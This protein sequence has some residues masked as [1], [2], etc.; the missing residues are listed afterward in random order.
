MSTVVIYNSK[1][2][3]TKRYADLI[4]EATGADC[5]SLADAKK[6]DLTTYD[7]IIFGS[8][9]CAG[10]MQKL[11]WFKE[12]LPKLEGKNLLVYLVGA[13]PI[14]NPDVAEGMKN[15]FADSCWD[16]VKRFYCPGGLNYEKMSGPSKFMM[17]AFAKSIQSKK[18]KTDKDEIMAN[19]LISSYDISDPKYLVP[20]LE[21]LV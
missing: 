21:A 19:M 11:N 8:W 2:G 14:Y 17:K 4:Q 1:T 3:F 20:L 13:S 5:F 18:D 12:Q 9:S 15:I 7:N 16:V 6:K 10:G